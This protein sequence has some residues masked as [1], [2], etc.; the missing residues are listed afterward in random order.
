MLRGARAC[1]TALAAVESS[2]ALHVAMNESGLLSPQI[3]GLTAY[4]G[5]V[6]AVAERGNARKDLQCSLAERPD[7]SVAPLEQQV[8]L[9]DPTQAA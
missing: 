2:N 4:L 5:P 1:F 6:K 7:D 8:A 3:H 9:Q